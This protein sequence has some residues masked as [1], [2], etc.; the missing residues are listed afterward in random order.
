MGFSGD[1][2]TVVASRPQIYTAAGQPVRV[3]YYSPTDLK[4]TKSLD[5]PSDNLPQFWGNDPFWFNGPATRLVYAGFAGAAGTVVW[6][7]A[8]GKQ[9]FGEA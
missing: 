5:L 8:A 9:L 2:A 4:I 7:L 6:D 3:D 1:G